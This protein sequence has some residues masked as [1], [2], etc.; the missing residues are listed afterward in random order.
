MHQCSHIIPPNIY[1]QPR[2]RIEC[3]ER[4][5]YMDLGRL[6]WE[7]NAS[8]ITMQSSE[9]IWRDWLRKVLTVKQ[10]HLQ[11]L[12]PIRL[13]LR[14]EDT[15]HWVKAAS[16]DL[17]T[18]PIRGEF[19][20]NVCCASV[21]LTLL[22]P[23]LLLVLP[24]KNRR[25]CSYWSWKHSRSSDDRQ[26]RRHWQE[27]CFGQAQH[28]EGLCANT[29]WFHCSSRDSHGQRHHL[30]RIAWWANYR[31]LISLERA[32]RLWSLCLIAGSSMHWRASR[33]IRWATWDQN[34]GLL[35]SL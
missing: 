10:G 14:W 11:H 4:Q 29:G 3:H 35:C 27:L 32:D 30:G 8:Y 1:R 6:S 33:I 13:L 22:F 19:W 23:K 16:S 17:P 25:S 15:V 9:E 18:R 24:Y 2:Q 34:K 31:G 12:H 26:P 20:I 21:I 28:G 7:V 5:R